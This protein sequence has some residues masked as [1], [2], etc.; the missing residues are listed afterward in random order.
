M[1]GTMKTLIGIGVAAAI[2]GTALAGASYADVYAQVFPG[3]DAP[4]ASAARA[5]RQPAARERSVQKAA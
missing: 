3:S 1:R 2:D 5:R 4:T